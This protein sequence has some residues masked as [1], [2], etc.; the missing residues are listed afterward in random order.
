MKIKFESFALSMCR[1]VILTETR[2]ESPSRQSRFS[3]LLGKKEKN[4][5]KKQAVPKSLDDFMA[6]ISSKSNTGSSV[7]N[8]K[9][10]EFH[11]MKLILLLQPEALRLFIR[12]SNLIGPY[13]FG[14]RFHC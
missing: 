5:T 14:A 2:S 10:V 13:C 6:N 11:F 9:G 3:E 7:A 4:E 1:I 8:K 12:T